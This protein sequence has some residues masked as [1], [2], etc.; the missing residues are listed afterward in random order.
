MSTPHR[1]VTCGVVS[2]RGGSSS[3]PYSASGSKI[4]FSSSRDSELGLAYRMDASN[5]QSHS[6]GGGSTASA[7]ALAPIKVAAS[8]VGAMDLISTMEAGYALSRNIKD[9]TPF[10]EAFVKREVEFIDSDYTAHSLI[11]K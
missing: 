5:T 4:P 8:L 1:G 2:S 7:N 3:R 10:V 6:G 9:M 11:Q